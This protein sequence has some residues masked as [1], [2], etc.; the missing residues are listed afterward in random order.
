MELKKTQALQTV[1]LKVAIQKSGR[2][3]DDSLRLLKDCGIEISNGVNKLKSEASNFPM[4][5][6]FCGTMIFPSMWR[7]PLQILVL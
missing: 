1:K 6:Y 4:E 7:T 2:L 5:V 3:H